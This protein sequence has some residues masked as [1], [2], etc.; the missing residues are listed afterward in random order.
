VPSMLVELV[1]VRCGEASKNGAPII[2]L[3]EQN[4]YAVKC[5]E[6]L[7]HRNVMR[8]FSRLSSACCRDFIGVWLRWSSAAVRE[9]MSHLDS[10][11][12][13]N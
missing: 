4:R 5:D 1:S 6:S 13:I 2:E 10:L 11:V 9:R 7:I 12:T 8:L 3:E